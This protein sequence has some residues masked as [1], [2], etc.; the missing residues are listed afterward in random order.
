[1]K[2]KRKIRKNKRKKK[3]IKINQII[4]LHKKFSHKVSQVLN[5]NYPKKIAPHQHP[6]LKL[7]HLMQLSRLV[8]KQNQILKIY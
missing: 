4:K 1:M 7:L 8:F 3:K 6:H 5:N 2:K